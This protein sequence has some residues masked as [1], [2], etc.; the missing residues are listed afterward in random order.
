MNARL[1]ISLRVETGF[2]LIELLVSMSVLTLLLVM[3]VQLLNGASG[4]VGSSTK[5]MDADTEA[6]MIF[7][8][9]AIDLRRM[10]KRPEVDYSS[11]KQPAGTLGTQYSN[12]AI[13]V[14]LQTDGNDQMAFYSETEGYFSGNAQPSGSQKAPVSLIAYMVANDSTTNQP[15]LRRLGKG[16]G[17]DTD[18]SGN[19]H[20]VVYLPLTLLGQWP[21]LFNSD[22]VSGDPDYGI[23]GSQVVRFEYTY[24]LKANLTDPSGTSYASKLSPIPYWSTYNTMATGTSV[25]TSINGFKDV[26]AIVVTLVL[27]DST[28]R[29]IVSDYS[30]LTNTTVFNNAQDLSNDATYKGDV[31]PAW[32]AVVNSSSFATTTGIPQSAVKGLRIYERF[33]YLDTM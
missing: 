7:N 18:A 24:L 1:N 4:A 10:I 3:V 6:R 25:H 8:R 11:F 19:W 13:P 16:L 5:H 29:A 27:M 15:S 14:N 17:W 21:N 23:V 32:N 33:F 22:P 26:A 12:A 20:S 30:K 2:T 28:T 31:A 9:L